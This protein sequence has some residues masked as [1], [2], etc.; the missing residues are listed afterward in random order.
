MNS[1]PHDVTRLLIAWSDGD[2]EAR[3]ELMKVVY[4]ELHRMA[5][6]YMT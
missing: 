2:Q 6:H 5:H 3:D 4:Q 1:S